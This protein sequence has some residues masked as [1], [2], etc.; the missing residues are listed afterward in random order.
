MLWGLDSHIVQCFQMGQKFCFSEGGGEWFWAVGS[1]SWIMFF[2]DL[3]LFMIFF[4]PS[5]QLTFLWHQSWF[6][7]GNRTPFE[8]CEHWNINREPILRSTSVSTESPLGQNCDFGS[9]NGLP[10]FLGRFGF[11]FRKHV[12]DTLPREPTKGLLGQNGEHRKKQNYLSNLMVRLVCWFWV[13]A[14][15][16]RA[17]IRFWRVYEWCFWEAS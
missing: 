13:F 3:C 7:E 1:S 15:V 2:L 5:L 8:K 17:R 9:I 4:A 11:G 12:F 6:M 10:N 14:A 16:G